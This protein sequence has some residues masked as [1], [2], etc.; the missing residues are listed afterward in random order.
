MRKLKQRDLIDAEIMA[1]HKAYQDLIAQQEELLE[2]DPL[3][4]IRKVALNFIANKRADPGCVSVLW[5]LYELHKDRCNH[6][7]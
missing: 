3:A 5:L 2:K 7:D 4:Y 1:R 6:S